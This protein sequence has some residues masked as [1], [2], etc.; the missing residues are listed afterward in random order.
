MKKSQSFLRVSF[1][2]LA[3]WGVL[4]AG[5]SNSSD[6]GPPQA[7]PV[8]PISGVDV[9]D[10]AMFLMTSGNITFSRVNTSFSDLSSSET[11]FALG[12]TDANVVITGGKL[13]LKMGTKSVVT[14]KLVNMAD[15]GATVTPASARFYRIRNFNNSGGSSQL[16]LSKIEDG[17]KKAFANLLYATENA[18]IS[19]INYSKGWNWMLYKKKTDSVYEAYAGGPDASFKWYINQL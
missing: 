6:D 13:T 19:G 2:F 7:Q 18:N 3:L 9:Y 5:C 4:F 16:Q 8:K 1:M 12:L 11:L 14:G 15:Y 17:R 10:F